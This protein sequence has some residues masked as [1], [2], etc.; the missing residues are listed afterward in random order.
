MFFPRRVSVNLRI[1]VTINE[2]LLEKTNNLHMRKQRRRSAADQRLCFRYRDY[3][4][5]LLIK[6]KISSY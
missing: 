1:L 6:S 4:I 2:P 5:P 3:R